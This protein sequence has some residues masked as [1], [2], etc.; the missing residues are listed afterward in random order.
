MTILQQKQEINRSILRGT[1]LKTG[2]AI[3]LARGAANLFCFAH[4]VSP[5]IFVSN[6]RQTETLRNDGEEEKEEKQ[7]DTEICFN[8]AHF[9]ML[10][11]TISF[12]FFVVCFASSSS[13]SYSPPHIVLHLCSDSSKNAVCL[14]LLLS[15][16]S[17]PH[18]A[19][20]RTATCATS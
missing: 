6:K 20:E 5:S 3:A 19:L 15:S 9:F 12:C 1:A 18:S 2:P 17:L 10:F 7:N 8:A 16:C 13:S 11:F 14:S 4:S